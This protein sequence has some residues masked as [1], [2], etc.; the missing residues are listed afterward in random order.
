LI[1]WDGKLKLPNLRRGSA[2]TFVENVRRAFLLYFFVLLAAQLAVA[3]FFS[4][5]SSKITVQDKVPLKAYPFDLQVVRL[6]DGP[7]RDAMLRD[8]NIFSALIWIGCCTTS[9][10]T[11]DCRLQ[12]GHWVDGRRPML[13]CAATV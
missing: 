5:E 6:L 11:R 3:A 7:F 9:A 4:Q 10:S 1:T 12:L 13:S 2:S 8:Q